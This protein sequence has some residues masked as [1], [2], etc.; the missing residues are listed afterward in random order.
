MPVDWSPLVK[1]IQ[2]H[3]KFTLTSHIRPDCDA[4]GSE[5]GLALVL[6]A[7]GKDVLIVNGQATPHN[8]AF[9]DPGSRI[10]CIGEDIQ[11]ADLSDREVHIVLDTSA[12]A[13]LGP[14]SEVI[15][16]TSAK[17]YIIDHHV[18]EDDI[19][20]ELFKDR[21][22]EA[23]G[24]LVVE[25][26]DALGVAITAE[27]A[28]PLYAAL[29]T[30][31][32]WFRF[33]S[34]TQTTY[35]MGGRLVAAGASPPA[36]YSD[37]YEQD[38]VGRVRLRGLILSRTVTELEGRLAHTYVLKEDYAAMGAEPTDTEDV[39]NLTLGI[40]GTEAAVILV[41]QLGGGFKISFRSRCEMNCSELAAKFGGGGHKAAAGAFVEGDLAGAQ[42]RILDAVRAAMR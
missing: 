32:G 16:T 21:T 11:P 17:K 24:R 9:I 27:M 31:T 1:I 37:L 42:E 33:G 2:D 40:A 5:L 14:M 3:Q 26:A 25:L 18:G 34:A 6:E 7:L 22:A 28:V 4:L 20:A 35:E 13:Q 15:K 19:G 8:L 41:E 30:D 23:T 12:W 29:A 38:S 36:I 39:I 10:H